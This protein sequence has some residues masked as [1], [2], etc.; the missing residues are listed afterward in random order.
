[1]KSTGEVLGL[2]DDFSGIVEAFIAS[3][4]M[5]PRGRILATVLM[6][7]RGSFAFITFLCCSGLQFGQLGEQLS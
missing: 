6:K 2:A 3:G 5:I 4:Y 7:T 1:M